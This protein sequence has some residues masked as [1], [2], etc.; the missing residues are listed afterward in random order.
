MDSASLSNANALLRAHGLRPRKRWGQNFL[1]DRNVLDRIVR[2]A[3]LQSGDRVLEVGPGLG[4]LTRRLAD[5]SAF[6][7]AVEIDTLL[8]P[9]LQET[10]EDRPNVRV[11]YQDFLKVDLPALLN[12][13]FGPGPGVVVAN[14]P[15][16]I[17]TPILERLLAHK[18]RVTRI[19][20]LV[21]LE[22]ADR[23]AARPATESYGSMT[24]FAQYHTRVEIAGSVSRNCFLPP[25][26]VNSAIVVFTPIEGGAVAVHDEDSFFRIVHAAFGQRRKTLPNALAGG[27]IGLDRPRAEALVRETGIDPARR[28]ETLSLQEFARLA[29]VYAS[30]NSS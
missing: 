27:D 18:G 11:V 13:A 2:A 24:V 12:E 4:A 26:E 3:A 5:S 10:L 9:I 17:T 28:G 14:I 8:E 15:Y 25:P 21:Q 23:L 29:D 6:V 1:C 7:T 19:V 22:F 20:L 30:R 16:Y